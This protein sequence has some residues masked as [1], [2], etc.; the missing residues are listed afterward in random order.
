MKVEIIAEAG[1]NHN[2]DESL[3]FKLVEAA[4]F[5]GADVVKFQTFKAEKL[6]TPEAEQAA[7]QI[8]NTQKKSLS[9]QC[10]PGLSY[11]MKHI[12]ACLVDVM[13]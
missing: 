11:R 12:T 1:V 13:N 10:Y 3:A 8:E 5:A 6:V 2:G 7:Y 9:C 4:S